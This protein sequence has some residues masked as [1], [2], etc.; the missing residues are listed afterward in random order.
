MDRV[1]GG[2]RHV[3]QALTAPLSAE[4]AEQTEPM[5]A[6]E[7]IKE[8]DAPSPYL[9]P[10][11]M[12][13]VSMKISHEGPDARTGCV[14]AAARTAAFRS[15]PRTRVG[16]TDRGAVRGPAWAE[17]VAALSGGGVRASESA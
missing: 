17:R 9:V 3:S 14:L 8:L 15:R 7:D 5:Y 6:Q 4:G 11:N 2:L 16:A 10:E 12:P 1:S 13:K